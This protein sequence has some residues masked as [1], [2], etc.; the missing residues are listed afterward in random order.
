MGSLYIPD[1]LLSDQ[2]SGVMDGSGREVVSQDDGLE[3]SFHELG[4]SE[5]QN[6]IEL[7]FTLAKETKSEASSHKSSTFED[8]LGIIFSKGQ[9]F[10]GGLSQLG[11][12]EIDSSDFSFILKTV[13]T[14]DL[15]SIGAEEGGK[16]QEKSIN[17]VR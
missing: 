10:S 17:M 14:Q 4:D 15:H 9:K 6:I 5:T 11:E 1:V 7:V 3:S 2:D 8:S 13:F 12:D 16:E